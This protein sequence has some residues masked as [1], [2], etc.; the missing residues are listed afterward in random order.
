MDATDEPLSLPDIA[1][2]GDAVHY[3][4]H[5]R[6]IRVEH[7]DQGRGVAAGERQAVKLVRRH[8]KPYAK[9]LRLP[10]GDF[11]GGVNK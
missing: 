3:P 1:A 9:R 7:L 2:I 10:C 8:G 4:P 11:G 5:G 6:V